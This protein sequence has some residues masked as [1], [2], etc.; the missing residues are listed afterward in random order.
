MI[1]A[2]ERIVPGVLVTVRQWIM[3]GMTDKGRTKPGRTLS[4]PVVIP[5]RNLNHGLVTI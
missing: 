3:A 5:I 2:G 4:A 1:L